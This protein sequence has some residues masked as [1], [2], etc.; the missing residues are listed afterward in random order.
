[1]AMECG[2]EL[3]RRMGARMAPMLTV[4]QNSCYGKISN[5]E[6]SEEGPCPAVRSLTPCSRVYSRWDNPVAITAGPQQGI[7]NRFSSHHPLVY[8]V[9][10]LHRAAAVLH[11]KR[12]LWAARQD[13]ARRPAA[14]ID[15]TFARTTKQSRPRLP[16]GNK[17]SSLKHRLMHQ[18]FHLL[19]DQHIGLWSWSW[20]LHGWRECVR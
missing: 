12:Y 20:W 6:Y 8:Y 17:R 4:E 9:S 14:S 18:S 3:S 2:I 5:T 13:I 19:G 11:H 16:S 7:K 1:M 10:I 15:L